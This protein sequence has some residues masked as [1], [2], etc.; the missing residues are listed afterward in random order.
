M[1]KAIHN[2]KTKSD[3]MVNLESLKKESEV[4]SKE[5]KKHTAQMKAEKR[6]IQTLKQKAS[7]FTNN[8]LMEVYLLRKADAE[9]KEAAVA[10]KS[11]DVAIEDEKK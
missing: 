9:K 3:L 4:L 11:A 7:Q 10:E 2:K 1:N 5:K 6:R 8:D